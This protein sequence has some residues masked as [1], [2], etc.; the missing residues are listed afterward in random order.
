[1]SD[2]FSVLVDLNLSDWFTNQIDLVLEFNSLE[3][4]V[5]FCNCMLNYNQYIFKCRLL[6]YDLKI[7]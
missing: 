6:S 2:L 4:I 5:L 1:M 3:F 7:T